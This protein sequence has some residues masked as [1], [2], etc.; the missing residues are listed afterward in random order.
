MKSYTKTIGF[1]NHKILQQFLIFFYIN[2]APELDLSLPMSNTDP[3]DFL[4]GDYPNSMVV[5]SVHP[6]EVVQ[7]NNS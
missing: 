4:A 3:T 7:V 5:L 2:I 6:Q 1:A